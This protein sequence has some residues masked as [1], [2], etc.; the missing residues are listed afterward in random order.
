MPGVLGLWGD[1]LDQMAYSWLP[2]GGN[3]EASSNRPRPAGDHWRGFRGLPVLLIRLSVFCFG[4]ATGGLA[5][6]PRLSK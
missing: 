6:K 5:R 2:N 1:S 3:Y 4:S